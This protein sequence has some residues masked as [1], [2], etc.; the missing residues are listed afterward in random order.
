LGFFKV[1]FISQTETIRS[2]TAAK[3]KTIYERKPHITFEETNMYSSSQPAL[4]TLYIQF[5]TTTTTA[6]SSDTR[7][8]PQPAVAL[9]GLTHSL[10]QLWKR[11]VAVAYQCASRTTTRSP[12]TPRRANLCV[13]TSMF[14]MGHAAAKTPHPLP[15]PYHAEYVRFG[16]AQSV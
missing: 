1:H 8:T 2:R 3:I 15:L 6:E 4:G 13:R 9:T 7:G 11:L 16:V 10:R 5:T 12:F 14:T